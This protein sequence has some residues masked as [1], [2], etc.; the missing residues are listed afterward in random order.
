MNHIVNIL[1]ELSHHINDASVLIKIK[2]VVSILFSKE[3]VRGTDYPRAIMQLTAAIAGD[4]SE[5]QRELLLTFVEMT[6]VFYFHDSE[7]CARQILWLH[8]LSWRH[9]M[10]ASTVL[11]PLKALTYG[12]LFGLYFHGII[13]HAATIQRLICLRSSNAE[14]TER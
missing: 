6:K 2:Q 4:V 11:C 9:S 7:L 10:S 1:K 12:K 14:Q 13:D 3:K 8:N 5:V